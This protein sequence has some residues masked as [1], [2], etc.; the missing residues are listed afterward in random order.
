MTVGDWGYKSV[1]SAFIVRRAWHRSRLS[2]VI[3]YVPREVG[4]MSDVGCDSGILV[5]LI[6]K[7]RNTHIVGIDVSGEF[8]RW[9]ERRKRAL[10]LERVYYLIA[11]ATFLPFRKGVFDA[12]TCSEVLEH[13]KSPRKALSECARSL[14]VGGVAVVT[15][16]NSLYWRVVRRLIIDAA[17]LLSSLVPSVI[18]A[19]PNPNATAN[20]HHTY[21]SLGQLVSLFNESELEVAESG[22]LLFGCLNLV[23]GTKI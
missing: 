23:T 5:E 21:F 16:P 10:G 2:K 14:K 19:K 9:S 12:L 20:L 8:I 22:R 3:S 4:L 13:V 6:A 18:D 1:T 7:Y 17:R 15:T 11:D